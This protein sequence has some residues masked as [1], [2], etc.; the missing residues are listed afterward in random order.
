M[1]VC[2]ELWRECVCYVDSPTGGRRLGSVEEDET[3]KAECSE[4]KWVPF[5]KIGES[6]ER[7]SVKPVVQRCRVVLPVM[8]RGKQ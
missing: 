3:P 1:G 4:A 6:G 5:V 2:K 7:R 8:H